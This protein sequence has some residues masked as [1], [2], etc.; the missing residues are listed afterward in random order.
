MDSNQI[1]HGPPPGLCGLPRNINTFLGL[2]PPGGGVII[3]E[4]LKNPNFPYMDRGRNPFAAAFA[5]PFAQIMFF[6]GKIE[7]RAERSEAI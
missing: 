6:F 5:A 3:L 2:P 4:K 7:Y 1:W